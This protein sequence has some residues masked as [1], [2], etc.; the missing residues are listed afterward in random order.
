MQSPLYTA[1][2]TRGSIY[3]REAARLRRSLERHNLEHDIRAIDSAG[4][5]RANAGL[6]ARHIQTIQR[7]YPTRPI[8]QLDADAFA[9]LPPTLFDV[10]PETGCD[11]AVHYRQGKE[12]LNGTVW[13]AP[14][15]GARDVID[16]Y[17]GYVA[18]DW[19][20]THNEQRMLQNAIAD[21]SDL[22]RVYRLPA[23]YCWI[24][25]IMA[26]DLVPGEEVV[27]EHLQASR[28]T[29]VRSSLTPGRLAR[30]K[31]IEGA[32]L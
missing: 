1:F 25:D 6:T 9:H 29:N 16:R 23:G 7:E 17:A 10:L 2:Y 26:D 5:W 19:P 24:H 11:I 22:I 15:H 13:L 32:N 8:V 30:I 31:E 21:L 27:I 14:T 20:R 3:E 12:M 18:R 4:D 28:E